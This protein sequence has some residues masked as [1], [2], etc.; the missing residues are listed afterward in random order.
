MNFF[1]Y[2][3]VYTF[4]GDNLAQIQVQL[5]KAMTLDL[6][7]KQNLQEP[8]IAFVNHGCNHTSA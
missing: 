7:L 3:Q 5:V 2:D 6:K 8:Q 1:R 4:A